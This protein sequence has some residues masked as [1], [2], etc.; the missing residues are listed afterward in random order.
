MRI[1]L[2]KWFGKTPDYE[3]RQICKSNRWFTP[4]D[5]PE[6]I[7]NGKDGHLYEAY[8]I[9]YQ[10]QHQGKVPTKEGVRVRRSGVKSIGEDGKMLEITT[11]STHNTGINHRTMVNRGQDE[12]GRWHYQVESSNPKLYSVLI[13]EEELK[14]FSDLLRKNFDLSNKINQALSQFDKFNSLGYGKSK[15]VYNNSNLN[16]FSRTAFFYEKWNKDSIMEYLESGS[17]LTEDYIPVAFSPIVEDN[18]LISGVLFYNIKKR[19]YI[20]FDDL[21]LDYKKLPVDPVKTRN[22]PY[23]KWSSL[24]EWLEWILWKVL[25]TVKSWSGN[26]NNKKVEKLISGLKAISDNY[27]LDWTQIDSD[28]DPGNYYNGLLD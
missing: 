22:I 25:D 16:L 8:L 23:I 14:L 13:T 12:H 19:I 10:R 24:K 27:K 20:S 11:T 6:H 4:E 2:E 15:S 17:E 1:P 28:I 9:E 18:L 21:S 7:R 5:L 3:I 26:I